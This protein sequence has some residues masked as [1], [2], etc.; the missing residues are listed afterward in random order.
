M[1][2]V[3][4]S[5]WFLPQCWQTQSSYSFYFGGT[6][7]PLNGKH[8]EVHKVGQRL[9]KVFLRETNWCDNEKC[10]QGITSGKNFKYCCVPLSSRHYVCLTHRVCS[11]NAA[12]APHFC[13]SDYEN[14]TSDW[15]W[16]LSVDMDCI[17]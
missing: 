9:L 12:V 2:L 14:R 10:P 13:F 16:T 8:H 4:A 7:E 5:Q 3:T 17:L 15:S 1:E 6:T 11:A